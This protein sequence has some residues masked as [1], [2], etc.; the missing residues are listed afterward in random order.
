MGNLRPVEPDL[1]FCPGTVGSAMKEQHGKDHNT[2]HAGLC[3]KEKVLESH[4]F[5]LGKFL[6]HLDTELISLIEVLILY[7]YGVLLLRL[8]H[9]GI[10]GYSN[11]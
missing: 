5:V 8:D 9:K 7:L 11:A 4:A 6:L 2:Y 3:I 10:I 1:S